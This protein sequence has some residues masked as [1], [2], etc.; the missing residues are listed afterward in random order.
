MLALFEELD[1]LITLLSVM[2]DHVRDKFIWLLKRLT[3]VGQI[4]QLSWVEIKIW[5]TNLVVTSLKESAIRSTL[6]RLLNLTHRRWAFPSR[7]ENKLI[8]VFSCD[9]RTDVAG[10]KYGLLSCS[11]C[12]DFE[13]ELWYPHQLPHLCDQLTTSW[14]TKCPIHCRPFADAGAA[15]PNRIDGALAHQLKQAIKQSICA[16]WQG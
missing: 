9:E 2:I 7:R 5:I 3:R 11:M 6:I 13:G 16:W 15:A 12:Y 8:F 14:L 4:L 10:V 1:L